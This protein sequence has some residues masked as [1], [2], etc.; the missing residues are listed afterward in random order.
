MKTVLPPST[1]GPAALEESS[2]DAQAQVVLL[3]A[4]PLAIGKV[5][6]AIMDIELP[7]THL[8]GERYHDA[9]KEMSASGIA[10]VVLPPADIPAA[11]RGIM[12]DLER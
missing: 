4:S 11:D 12:G 9:L 8:L 1:D 3:E 5:A 2:R 10:Q 6:D 7:V